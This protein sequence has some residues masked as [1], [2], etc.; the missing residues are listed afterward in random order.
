MGRRVS[1]EMPQVR[2]H[3]PSGNGR[4]TVGGREVY[5]G[6]HGSPEARQRYLELMVEHGY[7]PATAIPA[8]TPA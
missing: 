2:L 3:K 7:L 8:A 5:V 6:R 4:V 1:G